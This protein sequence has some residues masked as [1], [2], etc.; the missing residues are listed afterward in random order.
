MIM[1]PTITGAPVKKEPAGQT[2]SGLCRKVRENIN[3]LV[4]RT[5]TTLSPI[6][7]ADNHKDATDKAEEHFGFPPLFEE[8]YYDLVGI[9]K[10]ICAIHDIL[11][12]V[13]L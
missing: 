7:R 13:E 3:S 12:R 9:D 10:C 8:L 6:T 1:T 2:I 4:D 11:N 5:E